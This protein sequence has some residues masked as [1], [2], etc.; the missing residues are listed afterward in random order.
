MGKPAEAFF[1]KKNYTLVTLHSI[2]GV[3]GVS[4]YTRGAPPP[5]VVCADAGAS[6]QPMPPLPPRSALPPPFYMAES[7]SDARGLTGGSCTAYCICAI[8]LPL[9]SLD[10]APLASPKT[11]TVHHI[12]K[13]QEYVVNALGM[14]AELRDL[15]LFAGGETQ[16]LSVLSS[17]ANPEGQGRGAGRGALFGRGGGIQVT[18]PHTMYLWES[19]A[20]GLGK[21]GCWASCLGTGG[22]A[23][24]AGH[25]MDA[26]AMGL[27]GV[28]WLWALG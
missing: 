2:G 6:Q 11:P 5:P 27:L 14:T 23:P 28:P 18:R 22:A 16:G 21:G 12:V 25:T 10:A 17:L 15:K 13:E 8:L 24:A 1:L 4:H 20:G 7:R 9:S 19:L 26:Y 3:G